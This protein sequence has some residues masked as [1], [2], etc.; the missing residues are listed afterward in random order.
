MCATQLKVIVVNNKVILK[1]AANTINSLLFPLRIQ[2]K[3]N[4]GSQAFLA[5]ESVQDF[6]HHIDTVTLAPFVDALKKYRL[7]HT[8]DDWL[9][10]QAIRKVAG[11]ISP[12]TDNYN[13][14]TVFKWWLLVQTG[15]DAVI[16]CSAPYLLLYVQ[17]DENIYNIPFRPK[18]GKQYICLNYHDYGAIDFAQHLFA[19]VPIAFRQ[20]ERVFSYRV[21]RLPDLPLAG[22]A[23]KEVTFDYGASTYS[24]RIKLNP[25]VKNM[26]TNY[27]VV[28]YA[29]QF[30]MPLSTA[31]YE[32]LVPSLKRQVQG[33][34]QKE[35]IE[36]LLRFTRYAFL[37]KPDAEV[38]GGEKRL[39]PEQTLLHEYSDCEDRAALFFYLV[40][41]IYNLPMLVL[42]YPDHVTVAVKLDKGYGQTITH[43]GLTYS[44]CEPSPQKQD[45][46]VGQW[47][48]A[49]KHQ[50]YE[51]AYAFKPD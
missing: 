38:F 39:S 18:G 13:A 36:F 42:T 3:P 6:I 14:Y 21:T 44:I 10:Y 26:F 45:L 31:T 48:P 25:Q 50:A 40:K 19:E 41:E 47:L 16:T 51:V 34:K 11:A 28:D 17:C 8:S 22:Y 29:L 4:G 35:G 46:A 23:E 37:F 20:N 49:L 27:P 30:N 12:K 15:Y 33:W 7:Q 5:A 24:F 1:C 32:S 9:F 2:R 43:D